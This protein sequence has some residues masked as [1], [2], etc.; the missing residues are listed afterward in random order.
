[1]TDPLASPPPISCSC[2]HQP[3]AISRPLSLISNHCSSISRFSSPSLFSHQ[4]PTSTSASYAN[5][6]TCPNPAFTSKASQFLPPLYPVVTTK[7]LNPQIRPLNILENNLSAPSLV[8]GV[9]TVRSS[10]A[11]SSTGVA[12]SK[13]A[14]HV[15]VDGEGEVRD[16]RILKNPVSA[17]GQRQQQH[18][19]LFKTQ[20]NSNSSNRIK[21]IQ[22]LE[23]QEFN[24]KEALNMKRNRRIFYKRVAP[25]NRHQPFPPLIHVA[26]RVNKPRAAVSVTL[27]NSP[28]EPRYANEI[29]TGDSPG[30]AASKQ[31]KTPLRPSK[32]SCLRCFRTD[33]RKNTRLNVFNVFCNPSNL[34]RP[35]AISSPDQNQQQLQGDKTC[36]SPRRSTTLEEIQQ[37]S[38]SW[39]RLI[40]RGKEWSEISLVV[41]RVGVIIYHSSK[42]TIAGQLA[43]K[44]KIFL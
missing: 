29:T 44:R 23:H 16:G 5:R 11:G 3:S 33:A 21:C 37:T 10:R 34:Y 31:A 41:Y 13:T 15:A 43:I 2:N 7:L 22:D 36:R 32:P 19:G 20:I 1:M 26:P 39:I 42:S 8:P 38:V 40:P 6:R 18:I 17:E 14:R 30:V 12:G 4:P 9:Q 24:T 35:E 25:S 28:N 27:R